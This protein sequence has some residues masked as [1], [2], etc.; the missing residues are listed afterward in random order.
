MSGRTSDREE[1][2]LSSSIV[3]PSMKKHAVS[4][5]TVEKWVVENNQALNTSWLKLDAG[6]SRPRVFSKVCSLFPVK[7]DACFHVKLLACLC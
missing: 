5:R 2:S 6:R 3:G 7:K 4:R 1:P